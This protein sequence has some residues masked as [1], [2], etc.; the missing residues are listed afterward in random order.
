M[1]VRS[2]WAAARGPARFLRDTDLEGRLF[3]AHLT[4]PTLVGA[5]SRAREDVEMWK[6]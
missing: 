2:A 4:A 5:D 1:I 6:A 3:D